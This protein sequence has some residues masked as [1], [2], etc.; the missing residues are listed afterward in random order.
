M[1]AELVDDH[2]ENPTAA[3]AWTAQARLEDA[4]AD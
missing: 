3:A 1:D 4:R 2:A